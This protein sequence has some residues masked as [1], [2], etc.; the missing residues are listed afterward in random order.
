MTIADPSIVKV[1]FIG[2]G[3][4]NFGCG[5]GPWNHSIRLEKIL[6]SRLHVLGVVDPNLSR[7]E[8]QIGAKRADPKTHAAWAGATVFPNVPH[9][10]AALEAHSI[11]L[12]VNGCPPPFRGTT[13]K[14]KDLDMQLMK[15]FPDVRGL[16]I[17]KPI[18]SSDPAHFD[19][20]TVA[21][22]L[23]EWQA[24]PSVLSVGYMLRYLSPV[25]KIRSVLAEHNLVPMCV[26]A[27]YFM[28]YPLAVNAQWWTK[29]IW[30]GPV[31]EQ[32]THFVDLVR[33]LAG[34]DVGNE[35]V[36]DTVQASSVEWDEDAGVLGAQGFD[37]S[38][39][40]EDQRI[41]R[42]TTAFWKHQRG[43][44]ATLTH[45]VA[46]QGAEYSTEIEILADGWRFKLQEAYS[47]CPTLTIRSPASNDDTIIEY[48]NEDP[49]ATEF[50]VI[51]DALDGQS[52]QQPLSSWTDALQTYKLTWAIRRASEET[53]R[54]N[55]GTRHNGSATNGT[56]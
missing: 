48:P 23:R 43:T 15:H 55:K 7:A 25:A 9:A 34:S 8:S 18:S 11:T 14:G 42:L 17:E 36:M 24:K 56:S 6:G 38:L 26:S 28:A 30:G 10:A 12:I 53:R 21:F 3:D 51:V 4:I 27:R 16:L 39:I 40:Q 44:V 5:E 49:F 33:F 47:T 54:R 31:V 35:V 32:A 37:E 41:P 19:L 2:A 22:G 29:S 45:G 46:L 13:L 20:E 50:Q 1:L 52:D